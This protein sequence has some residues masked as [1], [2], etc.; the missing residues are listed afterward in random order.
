MSKK[1][2]PKVVRNGQAKLSSYFRVSH[3]L[4][5]SVTSGGKALK[6]QEFQ[7]KSTQPLIFHSFPYICYQ[8]GGAVFLI[9]Y[10]IILLFIGKPFY[11]LEMILGQFTSKGSMK[12]IQT[13]PLLKGEN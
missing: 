3:F 6:F 7:I 2:T 5:A 11:F 12:A 4:W 1:A 13:I 9:P 8:N 10:V